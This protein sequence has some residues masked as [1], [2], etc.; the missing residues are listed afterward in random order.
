MTGFF[1]GLC[2]GLF[3]WYRRVEFSLY[4]C[5]FLHRFFWSLVFWADEIFAYWALSSGENWNYLRSFDLMGL[6]HY[7]W[8]EVVLFFLMFL[9]NKCYFIGYGW[10]SVLKGFFRCCLFRWK[11]RCFALM[12][13]CL[14]NLKFWSFCLGSFWI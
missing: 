8:F 11:R 1:V 2:W 10:F 14:S 4:C 13:F 7:V 3:L 12:L 5:C 9:F 6:L